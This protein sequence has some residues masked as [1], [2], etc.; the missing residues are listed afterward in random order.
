MMDKKG[1]SSG[2]FKPILVWDL[3]TRLFHWLLVALVVCSFVTAKIGG[4]WMLYHQRSG[5]A[6]LALLGFRVMW[7]FV[8]SAPSRFGAF[9]AAPATVVR[10]ALTLLRRDT[11]HYP[12]HN[13]LGGWSVMAML[14]ALFIQAATGLFANDDIA[15]TGPL[16]HWVSKAASDRLT[17]I[18]RL[19]QN[20]IIVLVAVHVGAV[21][22]HLIYKRENLIAPM[23]TG[24][25]QWRGDPAEDMS[26]Q[27]IWRA[28]VAAG[29]AAG[30][31]YLLVR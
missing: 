27:P 25:K 26:Q 29:L 4:N 10:Y 14:L 5:A 18:H 2:G 22:F 8:G 28:A 21:L 16:Y 19:N 20:L 1:H 11:P 13:P 23:I 24:K 15:T 12:G 17:T 6:I 9:L 3:P 30:A 7:G 31:V